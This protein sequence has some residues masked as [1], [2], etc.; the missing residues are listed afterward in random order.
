MASIKGGVGSPRFE[1]F[2]DFIFDG[3]VTSSYLGNFSGFRKKSKA[4]REIVMNITD[5][6]VTMSP[7]LNT[8]GSGASRT[9]V[10]A[11]SWEDIPWRQGLAD[12]SSAPPEMRSSQFLGS[13][14]RA[15]R[16]AGFPAPQCLLAAVRFCCGRVCMAF[17][18]SDRIA[19]PGD[20]RSR[21]ERLRM[22]RLQAAGS[23]FWASPA[24]MR[25]Q[26]QGT[27]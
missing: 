5:Q 4:R 13:S 12:A 7:G 2:C 8:L 26:K 23:P 6:W 10:L 21:E 3:V 27:Q 15:P 18:R 20:F 17:T 9:A 19:S 24:R 14:G 25:L 22:V 16:S 11:E 1:L